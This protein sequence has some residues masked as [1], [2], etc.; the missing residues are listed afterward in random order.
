MKRINFN[1]RSYLY[2]LLIE[3]KDGRAELEGVESNL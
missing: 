1:Q 3:I 2:N